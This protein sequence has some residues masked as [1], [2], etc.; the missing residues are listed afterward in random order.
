[1]RWPRVVA[2]LCSTTALLA[3]A[4]PA[5]PAA[6]VPR[7]PS[8]TAPAAVLM[9]S[10]T[11]TPLYRLNAD[12]RRPIAS[13]T[14]LMTALLTIEHAPLD[15]VFAYP[16]YS[17]S[18]VAS[19]I[20]LR[21]GERMSVH[22][23]FIA[24]ML[25]S[26]DDAAQDLA[27]NIGGHSVTRF[28][29]MMNAR[30]RQLA[31]SHTHYTTPVGLDTQGNY[32]SASDLVTL[33]SF[34]LSHHPFFAHVVALPQAVLHTGDHPRVVS[35]RNTLV[36]RVPWINGVKTGHTLSAGYVLVGSG[37]RGG[38]TLVSA[39]LGTPTESARSS[40]TL[41]LLSYGFANFRLFNPVVA[42]TVLARPA[43]R[44]RPGVRVDVIAGRS[45]VR[46]LPRATSL[47]TQIL[48][49][50]ELKGPIARHAVV[51]SLLVLA[52]GR[53]IARVPLLLARQLAAVSALTRAAHFVVRPST[54]V[55][56]FGLLG[57][58]VVLGVRRRARSRASAQAGVDVEPA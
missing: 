23:L 13:A 8:L 27:Y 7:P 49:P 31:L 18:S 9:E 26:A 40:D 3:S 33:A 4:P 38:M 52:D 22:D 56:L 24:M 1:V 2:A 43:V 35:N 6:P 11:G 55:L 48:V 29:G 5:A 58:V 21:P 41:A 19:Q 12:D 30:A 57:G 54:L 37:T 15:A 46:V 50:Q 20:G 53:P 45:I 51:G 36:G 28:I 44:Y 39:V 34:L 17:F 42:G 10:S 32:S 16:D 14:K 47:T 25:P